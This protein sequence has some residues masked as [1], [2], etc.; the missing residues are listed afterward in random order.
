[1]QITIV[2][3][4]FPILTDGGVMNTETYLVNTS[5]ISMKKDNLSEAYEF[6]LTNVLEQMI[7]DQKTILTSIILE[8][9]T[10]IENDGSAFYR[11]IKKFIK[12]YDKQDLRDK[13]ETDI[14]EFLNENMKLCVNLLFGLEKRYKNYISI[15]TVKIK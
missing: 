15:E 9:D 10:K 1:M 4:W 14:A 6:I 11:G 12:L 13:D 8:L 3:L 7:K 5:K 2:K